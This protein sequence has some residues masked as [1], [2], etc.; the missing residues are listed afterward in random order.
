[1]PNYQDPEMSQDMSQDMSQVPYVDENAVDEYMNP[2][3]LGSETEVNM[4]EY[5]EQAQSI[6]IE[7]SKK[8]D[9]TPELDDDKL[10]E[11]GK[12]GDSF[13]DLINMLIDHYRGGK[14]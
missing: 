2:T 1:M 6:L 3:E 13:D 4:V 8:I 11:I 14:Q 5:E 10:A 12:K 9:L 7:Y